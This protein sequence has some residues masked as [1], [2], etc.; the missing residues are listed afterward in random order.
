MKRSLLATALALTLSA[1]STYVAVTP[2]D[3]PD[4]SDP[5]LAFQTP[6]G[7]PQYRIDGSR[8]IGADGTLLC[9]IANT[10]NGNAYLSAFRSSLRARNFEV[11]MLPPYSSIASCPITVTY[12]V[13]EQTYWVP[14]VNSADITVYRN[15]ERVGKAVYNAN[16]SSG[17][18]NFSNLVPADQ[19]IEMLVERLFPGLKPQ[20]APQATDA[21][22][23]PPAV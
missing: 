6:S 17:G 21:A 4:Q 1:C 7:V 16:R 13:Q 3:R 11:K 22:A 9:V 5:L 12:V 23:P 8:V 18:L 15:G 19:T 10:A 2:V 14:F 20:P